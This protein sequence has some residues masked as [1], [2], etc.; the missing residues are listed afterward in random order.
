MHGIYEHL[1]SEV[2][3]LKGQYYVYLEKH[4]A[5]RKSVGNFWKDLGR[6]SIKE[7]FMDH[8]LENIEKKLEDSIQIPYG[9]REQYIP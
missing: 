9:E 1:G 4:D 7:H 5:T 8:Y 3:L 6:E 2:I